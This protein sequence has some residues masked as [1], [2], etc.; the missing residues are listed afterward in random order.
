MLLTT[1]YQIFLD[2]FNATSI[3]DKITEIGKESSLN[4]EILLDLKPELVVGYSVST[5]D[6]SLTTLKKAGLNVIY[7]RDWLEETPLGRA[8]WIQFFGVLFNKEKQADSIFKVIE[9]NYLSAK[10]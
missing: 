6:K 4:T 10:K 8:E 5:A 7:N 3:Y 1:F 2:R 9:Q